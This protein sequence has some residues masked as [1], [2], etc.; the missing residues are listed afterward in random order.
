LSTVL[1]VTPASLS[2]FSAP[3]GAGQ[4]PSLVEPESGAW[5]VVHAGQLWVC[6]SPGPDCFERVVF[7]D[8]TA[9]PEDVVEVDEPADELL[10]DLDAP[11]QLEVG[12]DAWQIGF[13][14]PRSL[15]VEH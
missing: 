12:V 11:E 3:P 5:A 13:W 4:P 7:D 10:L 15:W 1:L 6:W 2:S 9:E 8:D 14:G